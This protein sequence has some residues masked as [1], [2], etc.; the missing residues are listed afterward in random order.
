MRFDNIAKLK[1][2][3]FFRSL[4][5][6]APIITLF[7]FSRNLNTFQVVSLEAFLIATVVLAEIPT[8]IIADKIGRKFSLL[9]LTGLYVI[10]NIMTIYSHSYWLFIVIQII[11]GIAIA[12]GSGAI[13][14]LVYDSLKFQGKK[15]LMSK[16]WGAIN[17]YSLVAG[18]IAV[19][20]GGYIAR[21]L[22]PSSF[23]VL[24]W[25]YVIGS[26]IAFIISF[27][28]V[29]RKHT[30]EIK[31]KSPL[32]LF[33]E[34]SSQILKNKSLRKIVYL[35]I[36]TISFSH[37]IMFLFQPYFLMANVNSSTFGIIMAIGLILGALLMKYAYRIEELFGMKKT[38]F[39]ATILP[40]L[41][42]LL[43]A[44]LIGPI[45]SALWYILLKGSMSMKEPLFSQYQNIHIKSYNRAT[46]L[47]VI[48]MITSLYLVIMRFV[49]GAIA[50]KD[51]LVSFIVMGIIIII[52]A[53]V[54]RI[55][56]NQIKNNC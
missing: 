27:L 28:V 50:N 17:S 9:F 6:F 26:S 3:Y 13:E 23:I 56:E 31:R 10:G 4:Y 36:F 20:V 49:I 25:L 2:I 33:K 38:I 34:S 8:G 29:E 12:F 54:F 52:G 14:A 55:D 19:I 16:V 21:N 48:S 35:S 11:F 37:I 5:F 51:L 7:Y 18:V 53:I 32:I 39:I 42:Y 44:F 47:S 15:K 30:K 45:M 41:F 40:G 22:E 24:L 46:V 43:M 1:L